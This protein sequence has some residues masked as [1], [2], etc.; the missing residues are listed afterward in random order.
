MTHDIKMMFQNQVFQSF[1][2]CIIV[3]HHA[4]N[5]SISIVYTKIRILCI[6]LN[7][8]YLLAISCRYLFFYPGFWRSA[9][10]ALLTYVQ[11]SLILQ[12]NAHFLTA[13]Y[14]GFTYVYSLVIGG[15]ICR[16]EIFMLL[17]PTTQL[18]PH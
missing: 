14:A 12:S 15:S 11:A 5:K 13:S 2:P 9:G 8:V 6:P 10:F 4:K 7:R 17:S 16:D 1:L 18:V 3:L